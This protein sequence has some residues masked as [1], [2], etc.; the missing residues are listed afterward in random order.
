MCACKMQNMKYAYTQGMR[1]A[2]GGA[3]RFKEVEVHLLP[4]HHLPYPEE[5][6]LVA[7]GP[8]LFNKCAHAGAFSHDGPAVGADSQGSMHRESALELELGHGS[9]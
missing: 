9:R 8:N 6:A 1:D 7:N 3:D 5:W 2:R 4:Q